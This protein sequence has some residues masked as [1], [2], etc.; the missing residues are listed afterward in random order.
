M[1]RVIAREMLAVE[2]AERAPEVGVRV[3]VDDVAADRLVDRLV[4]LVLLEEPR[5]LADVAHEDE[6]AHLRVEILQRVDELQHEARHVAHRVRDVAQ[7]DDLRLDALPPVEADL[8]RHAAVLEVLA[9][10]CP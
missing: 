2:H 9:A 7:H 5:D 3:D 10:A 8:E 4:D 1:W 6:G